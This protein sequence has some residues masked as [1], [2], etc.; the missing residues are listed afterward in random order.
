MSIRESKG[1]VILWT[2]GPMSKPQP[3]TYIFMV[4]APQGI[5]TRLIVVNTG[6]KHYYMIQF[7]HA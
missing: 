7:T 5:Q 6:G 3:S 2:Y 1:D 4:S